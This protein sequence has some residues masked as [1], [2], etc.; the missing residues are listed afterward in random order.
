MNV[1]KR[2]EVKSELEL[3]RVVALR[4]LVKAS[5]H[6]QR[7]L[8]AA[9]WP[10]Y[11]ATATTSESSLPVGCNQHLALNLLHLSRY[12]ITALQ[13][14]M[15]I[16]KYY[17]RTRKKSPA[18]EILEEITTTEILEPHDKE[19]VMR[20]SRPIEV[21]ISL[22]EKNITCIAE[23]TARHAQHWMLLRTSKRF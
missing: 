10:S 22:R 1:S 14:Q 7:N 12:E 23:V 8:I 16:L 19:L 3:H 5:T 9:S 17:I 2:R 6:R 4:G 21:L 11:A 18:V 20:S 15:R 13:H